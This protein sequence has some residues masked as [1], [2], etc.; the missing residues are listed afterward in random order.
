MPDPKRQSSFTSAAGCSSN[1]SGISDILV[2]SYPLTLP[3]L[4]N[5]FYGTVF[6]TIVH[7]MHHQFSCFV[8]NTRTD[9]V[10][11]QIADMTIYSA[12]PL[13]HFYAPTTTS[14]DIWLIYWLLLLLFLHSQ[15]YV[16]RTRKSCQKF[17]VQCP[18]VSTTLHI[19][20]ARAERP[21]IQ[22]AVWSHQND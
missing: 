18:C 20:R 2:D 7:K 11:N 19:Q 1:G 10:I 8:W 4:G 16:D 14:T 13:L 21:H 12:K 5:V 22:P 17:N 15:T 9:E 3:L 6:T